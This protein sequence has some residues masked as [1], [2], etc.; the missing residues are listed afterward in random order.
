MR[1]AYWTNLKANKKE[2]L[3]DL[4][5]RIHST[6]LA[7]SLEPQLY[8][9]ASDAALPGFAPAVARALKKL[10]ALEPLHSTT[11]ALP[12]SP[13]VAQLSNL[14]AGE[15]LPFATI[16][17]L[18]QGMPRSFPFHHCSIL[19]HHPSFGAATE[20][21]GDYLPGIIVGDHW[22]A[23]GRKR[24]L[25]ALA[26]ADAGQDPTQAPPLSTLLASL[27]PIAERQ[28]HL[29]ASEPSPAQQYTP[30]DAV[31]SLIA[32][33]RASL[34]ENIAAAQMPHP[35]EPAPPGSTPP[36]ERGP[37]KKALEQFFQPLG[38]T[39]Q[40]KSGVY[41][42]RRHTPGRLQVT[43]ELDVG[44]WSHQILG[45]YEVQGLGFRARLPL[46]AAP[47]QIGRPQFPIGDA[48]NW[49]KIVENVARLVAHYD[50]TLTPALD[51]AA[52]PM[53]DYFQPNS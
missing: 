36:E 9:H 8:L 22:W 21:F 49:R 32:D 17:A 50:A 20:P 15:P 41:K 27:G 24:T 25:S 26:V 23:T 10:P 13:P 48:E 3:A 51:A 44:T 37:K 11:P 43:V 16:L 42:L 33:Y 2:P 47:N 30:P 18:A 45:S 12:F 7:S 46:P 4:L 52:G 5:T 19:F 34:S 35:L 1:A 39:P 29:L 38:Y 53:P 14:P 6:L 28:Q 40:Y 31:F